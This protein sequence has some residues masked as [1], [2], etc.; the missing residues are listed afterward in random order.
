MQPADTTYCTNCHLYIP[1]KQYTLHSIQCPRLVVY[2]PQCQSTVR[3]ADWLVHTHCPECNAVMT[4]DELE[5]HVDL[6]HRNVTC[7]CG[8]KV[9]AESLAAH[10]ADECEL[11][12]EVCQYCSM[13]LPHR[14]MPDHIAYEMARSVPCDK[15]GQNVSRRRMAIHLATAHGINPSLRP[16]DRSSMGAKTRGTVPAAAAEST[17]SAAAGPSDD[18]DQEDEMTR[19]LRESRHAAGL[20]GEVDED[21]AVLARVLRESER[22]ATTNGGGRANHGE[23]VMSDEL[24]AEDEAEAAP[25]FD[26]AFD[27][28][29]EDSWDDTHDTSTTVS[30]TA[31]VAP[32]EDSAAATS[33]A[34]GTSG[35][36][37]GGRR[38]REPSM[39]PYC[40]SEF[41][42]YEALIAH[43]AVCDQ[44]ED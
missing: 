37:S 7:E 11:R 9:A 25:E 33:A 44:M 39:C 14:S 15:C 29:E 8:A 13:Q 3:K 36:V 22:E 2:C 5:K 16:G 19:V 27:A 6:M 28:N 26:D 18:S 40:A 24:T 30:S 35:N 34:A 38:G 10:K 17:V 43:M 21:D 1:N 42:D 12:L 20:T 31:A 4:K 41:D 32:A 23:N